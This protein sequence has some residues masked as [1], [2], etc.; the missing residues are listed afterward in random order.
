MRVPKLETELGVEVYSTHSRGVGGIIRREIED[1]VVEEVLVDGSKATISRSGDGAVSATLGSSNSR[2]RYLVCVLVKRDWDTIRAIKALADGL[3]IG[4]GK[5]QTAGIKDA[6]A[7]TAQHITIEGASPED[8]QK[9]QIKDLDIR[10]IGYVRYEL[11]SYFLFGNS[12]QI[13][14]SGLQHSKKFLD[15]RIAESVEE[16][17]TIGGFPNFFGH[18]RFG[19]TRPVTH[20]VGKALVQGSFGD[21]VMLF[22]TKPSLYE[23]PQSIEVRRRLAETEDFRQALRDFP[24]QLHYERLMLRRLAQKRTDFAGAYKRLPFKLQEL[25]IQAYQSFLFNRFLSDRIKFKLPLDEAQVGDYV[26]K[27]ERNGLPM[28]RMNKRVKVADLEKTNK[29]LRESSLRLAIPLMG[30]RQQSS[31]G[32]QGNIEREILSEEGISPQSFRIKE[33]PE[34]SSKGGL[35]TVLTPL[36]DFSFKVEEH[37]AKHQLS[38]KLSFL[39]HRGSYATVFLRE[40]MKPSDLI[41]AGF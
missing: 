19:T 18:Q 41:K 13:V 38:M 3:K 4:S 35:R 25:F 1:F 8:V 5:I 28:M 39:L 11:S 23:H 12:F 7:V 34:I 14:I 10:P 9:I 17:E 27:V 6:K 31:L 20:L 33:I 40:L 29:A 30:F 26:V 37:Y 16:I 15:R 21:A 24:E 36:N 2:R 32:V 22:L